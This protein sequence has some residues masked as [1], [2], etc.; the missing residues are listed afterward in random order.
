MNLLQISVLMF[1][2]FPARVVAVLSGYFL[3]GV[4]AGWLWCETGRGWNI[5]FL[6][7]LHSHMHSERI[8]GLPLRK[9]IS[10]VVHRDVLKRKVDFK[11]LLAVCVITLRRRNTAILYLPHIPPRGQQVA[12]P[13]LFSLRNKK[14]SMLH[15]TFH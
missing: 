2:D 9:F 7:A 11:W 8:S 1:S 5:L 10:Q 6:M 3:S 12:S 15:Y 4:T 13:C 14:K